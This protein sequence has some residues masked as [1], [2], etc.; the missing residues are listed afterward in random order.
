M[1]ITGLI[2][3]QM[4]KID[5]FINIKLSNISE[6]F[7]DKSRSNC[8]R[9]MLATNGIWCKGR[10]R[11]IPR[12]SV[13]HW[14]RCRTRCI[15]DCV[16]FRFFWCPEFDGLDGLPDDWR[17]AIRFLKTCRPRTIDSQDTLHMSSTCQLLALHR[18]PYKWCRMILFKGKGSSL[19]RTYVSICIWIRN[20]SILLN[21]IYFRKRCNL[22]TRYMREPLL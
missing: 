5:L 18:S 6:L 21:E 8:P 20:R 16:Y 1:E 13:P 9:P 3:V 12:T 7:C 15:W 22:S 11:N 2:L 19:L 17:R 10:T 4:L 14:T